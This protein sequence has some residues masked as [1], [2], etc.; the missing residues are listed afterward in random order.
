M[1]VFLDTATTLP[2]A[3]ASV[4][5]TAHAAE[6]PPRNVLLEITGYSTDL[7][8]QICVGQSAEITDDAFE[9]RRSVYY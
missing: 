6:T 5:P 1:P 9:L 2:S 4:A 7:E 8:I 3:L